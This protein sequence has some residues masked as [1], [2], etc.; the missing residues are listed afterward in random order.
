MIY[1]DNA[2]T[3]L[4]KPPGVSQA[5]IYALENFGAASRATH[6]AAMAATREIYKTREAV[7]ALT[8]AGSPASV[9]LTSSATEALNLAIGGLLRPGDRV[10]TTAAEH[11]S[12]LR[13][14]YLCG[15]EPEVVG[16][17]ENGVIDISEARRLI[18]SGVRLFAV[19]HGS[20]V[21]GGITDV[22][23][24]REICA[25]NGVTMLLDV[26]QTL[27]AIPVRAD[28]ADVICFTGHKGLFGPQ[29][30]G[31]VIADNTTFR[32]VK[33]GGSGV[34]SFDRKQSESMPDVFEAG[35][36]SAHDIYGLQKG[37]LFV[38]G[39]GVGAIASKNA[40][41]RAG[42]VDKARMI[43]RVRVYGNNETPE[44][45]PVVSL[46]IS[47]IES[48]D[49]A[50]LLWDDHGIAVR[51]GFHCAPLMHR[52]LGTEKTGTVRFSFSYFN[53]ED[54]VDRCVSALREIAGAF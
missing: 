39:I 40:G 15:C 2:A 26:S 35:T 21:T 3:T 23:A 22:Y 19:T 16:C 53:T 41:L 5:V 43:D 36:H 13:P 47:G 48:A 54:D 11:N 29:G 17:D 37:V 38:T 6:G 4:V 46:N 44:A 34:N 25:K 24:L 52:A 9:A 49:V 27:G 20:N 1:C 18:V 8:G 50:S 30:S 28:M 14:I 45:L 31:G 33:T 7:A 12:V 32:I 10:V 51:A 42:F